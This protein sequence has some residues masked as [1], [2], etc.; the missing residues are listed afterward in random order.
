MKSTDTTTC[1][2]SEKSH[3][4]MLRA[5]KGEFWTIL[6]DCDDFQVLKGFLEKVA[7]SEKKKLLDIGCG[8]ARTQITDVVKKHFH[9]TGLDLPDVIEN[10][11]KKFCPDGNYI[12][13]NIEKEGPINLQFLR[14]FDVVVMNAF[15]DVMQFPL[16]ILNRILSFNVRHVIIHRQKMTDGV[17]LVER[18]PSYGGETYCSILNET[19]FRL[20]YEAYHYKC[21]QRKWSKIGKREEGIFSFVLE[22]Q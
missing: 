6:E 1:W 20:A 18:N 22:K 7:G 13:C 10:V 12:K 8:G 3:E 17:S 5:A 2:Y 14:A 9:Y 4:M 21:I 19:A 16:E 15:I 11:A